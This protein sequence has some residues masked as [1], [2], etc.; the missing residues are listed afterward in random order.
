[1]SDQHQARLRRNAT[2]AAGSSAWA[3]LANVLENGNSLVGSCDRCGW[4]EVLDVPALVEQL[5]GGFLVPNLADV[6]P[7]GGCGGGIEVRVLG[8]LD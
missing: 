3:D 4:V 5:S 8:R 1:M 6:V 7:C 2:M